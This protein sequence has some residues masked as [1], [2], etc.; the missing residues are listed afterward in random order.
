MLLL[1]PSISALENDESPSVEIVN[2]KEGYLHLFGIPIFPIQYTIA[3]KGFTLKPIQ[4][5][6]DDDFDESEDLLVTISITGNGIFR[7]INYST[8]AIWNEKNGYHELTV[9]GRDIDA[10]GGFG[11]CMLI[12]TVE[13]SSGNIGSDELIFIFLF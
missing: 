7:K 6:A 5:L 4:I 2:P 10:L 1:L 3:L 9:S 8:P 13:D 12:A 11:Y